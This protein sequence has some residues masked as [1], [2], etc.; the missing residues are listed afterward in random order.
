MNVPKHNRGGGGGEEGGV[1]FIVKKS[2]FPLNQAYG[3][4]NILVFSMYNV[5]F[6]FPSFL[7]EV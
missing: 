4:S 1:S 7:L 2:T 6:I 5:V 3:D